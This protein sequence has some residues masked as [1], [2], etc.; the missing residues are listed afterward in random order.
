MCSLTYKHEHDKELY[1]EKYFDCVWYLQKLQAAYVYGKTEFFWEKLK[2]KWP[3]RNRTWL[4]QLKGN[5]KWI[6][7]FKQTKA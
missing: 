3:S 5:D 4:V 7:Y 6:G 1:A 2:H